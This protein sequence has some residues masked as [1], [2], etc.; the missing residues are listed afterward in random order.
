M[1]GK[2]FKKQWVFSV[3]SSLP[4]SSNQN[5]DSSSPAHVE[6]KFF[7]IG[8]NALTREL[9]HYAAQYFA[10]PSWCGWAGEGGG[11]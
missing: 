1:Q 10:Y 9:N 8:W 4:T 7:L 2:N 5:F 11:V 3:N 6:P